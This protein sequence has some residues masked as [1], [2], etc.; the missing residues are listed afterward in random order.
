VEVATALP[1]ARTYNEAI[2]YIRLRPCGCGEM[3]ARWVDVPLTLEGR[4]ARYF[5]GACEGCGRGR[6]F[7]LAIPDDAGRRDDVVFGD[8]AEPSQII[9]PGEWLSVSDLYGQRV[10]EVL[11]DEAFGPDD[12]GVVHYALSARVSAID[13][14][15]KFLPPAADVV[16]EWF[17]RSVPGRAVYEAAPARFGRD[18][19]HAERAALRSNLERFV[20][21][22]LGATDDGGSASG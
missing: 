3:E 7:T 21:D 10:D 4:P 22:Y 1:Y 16:P 11:S 12:V 19:L 6:E 15:L 9:D 8:G 5:T 14:V 18:A 17:F 20:K 2:L 13:E